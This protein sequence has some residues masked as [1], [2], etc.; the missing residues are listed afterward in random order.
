MPQV[1]ATIGKDHYATTIQ[2]G[3]NQILADEPISLGG[4]DQGFSPDELLA[5]ALAACTLITLRMYADRK[6]Y[7]LERINVTISVEWNK[8]ERR[9][10]F[11]K[12]LSFEGSLQPEEVVRLRE[13]A[14]KCPTHVLLSSPIEILTELV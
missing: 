11:R 10:V 1:K 5:S 7:A 6:Q 12:I 9:S 13:I 8:E 3:S 14:D 2:A 4:T